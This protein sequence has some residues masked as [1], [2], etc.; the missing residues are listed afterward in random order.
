MHVGAHRHI[1]RH[2]QTHRQTHR[3]TDRQTQTQTGSVG[4]T[5]TLGCAI[6][7]AD[8][9]LSNHASNASNHAGQ[10][11]LGSLI[12]SC[13]RRTCACVRMCV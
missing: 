12:R 8:D 11:A 2:R 1:Y 7:D 13:D 3:R 9:R 10:K 4:R 6:E 5:R